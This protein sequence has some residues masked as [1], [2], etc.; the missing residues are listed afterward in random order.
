MDSSS[1]EEKLIKLIK[2][3]E[4]YIYW[5]YFSNKPIQKINYDAFL[6]IF[7]HV[8]VAITFLI[9]LLVLLQDLQLIN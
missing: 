2:I 7:Y 1:R 3:N 5:T 4:L 9:L 8:F 6:S